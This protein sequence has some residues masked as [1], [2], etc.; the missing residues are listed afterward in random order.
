MKKIAVLL[1]GL[2][3]FRCIPEFLAGW[4]PL[5]FDTVTY[6][7]PFLKSVSVLGLDA[8]LRVVYSQTAFLM[9]L[10]LFPIG[11]VG[12]PPLLVVKIVS[13][14]L[15]SFLGLACFLILRDVLN[16]VEKEAFVLTFFMCL[17]FMVLR[18]SWDMWRNSLGLVFYFLS[19]RELKFLENNFHGFNRILLFSVLSVF[20][21]EFTA[22]LTGFT[23]LTGG[24]HSIIR[25]RKVTFRDLSL[26]LLG[27]LCGLIVFYYTRLIL[28]FPAPILDYPVEFATRSVLA[29]PYNYISGGD[30]YGFEN[31]FEAVLPP[32]ILVAF[33]LAPITPLL[34]KARFESKWLNIFL[35]FCLISSLSIVIY[36]YAAV[37]FW[38]RWVFML[39][40]PFLFYGF[41]RLSTLD[42]RFK[43]GYF[44]LTLIFALGYVTLPPACAFPYYS[45]TPI[46]YRYIPTSMLQNSIPLED[47]PSVVEVLNW[48][49]THAPSNSCLMTYEP[50]TGWSR[51][52]TSSNITVIPFNLSLE[53]LQTGLKYYSH[54]YVIWWIR[55]VGWY[56][57]NPPLYLTVNYSYGRIAV[58]SYTP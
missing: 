29:F 57:W 15:F 20:S 3:L 9:Y 36:P 52:Y 23:M 56:N 53:A 42:K 34:V 44:T 49:N 33:T 24:F 6:Y 48:L 45:M 13:P 31:Y 43:Y 8:L 16:I 5:G 25:P 2:F 17:N 40:Y 55:G 32:L 47:S 58:Y 30:W 10:L 4:I 46:T 35:F 1:L 51:L 19:L 21:S 11:L 54:V 39:V 26:V 14:V 18:F 28:V 41:K 22:V 37:P 38:H 50:F 27:V 12:A 7:A